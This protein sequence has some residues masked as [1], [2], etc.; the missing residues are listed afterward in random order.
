M[1]LIQ[2]IQGG[3]IQFLVNIGKKRI[4]TITL[5]S[6]LLFAEGVKRGQI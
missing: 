1:I 4:L 2:L 5:L 3:G 6:C